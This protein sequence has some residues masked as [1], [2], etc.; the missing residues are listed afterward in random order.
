MNISESFKTFYETNFCL[1]DFVLVSSNGTEFPCHKIVLAARSE[2]F[3]NMLK[4][5]TTKE[6]IEGRV[7]IQDAGSE[8]LQ[9]MIKYLY[10]DQIPKDSCSIGLLG[11]AEKYMLSHL[12]AKSLAIMIN[13]I[14]EENCVQ[15][16]LAGFVY[17]S[18]ELKM[19][20]FKTIRQHWESLRSSEEMLNLE[21][22]YP[23]ASLEITNNFASMS[24]IE[25]ENR[26]K[27]AKQL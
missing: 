12:K 24:N 11:L 9:T 22:Q 26:I 8:D 21:T 15:M 7:E 13:S 4:H 27:I 2:V 14:T 18:E 5:H 23:K 19:A 16:F 25:H 6:A 3:S 10:T 20:A 17:N 1:T